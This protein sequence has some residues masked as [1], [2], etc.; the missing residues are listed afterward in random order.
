VST[1]VATQTELASLARGGDVGSLGALLETYRP[2]LYAT[3]V[4]LLASRA[5]ALDAVQETCVVA[6][7]RLGDLRDDG[8]ARAWLHAV[9]RNVCL[10]RMRERRELP[11]EIVE[12]P[13]ST[14]DPAEILERHIARDWV[15]HALDALPADELLTIVLRHFTRCE[16]YDAIARLTA[17]PV[18]TV[19]SRLSRARS[20]LAATMLDAAFGPTEDHRNVDAARREHWELFY[21]ELHEHPAPRTYKELFTHNVD[22]RDRRGHW[23]G[24][25]DWSAHEREAIA[26]GVRA[27]IV[28]VL[29]SS[30]L[31]VIEIDFTNPAGLTHCPPQAT[32]VHNLDQGRSHLLRIHYPVDRRRQP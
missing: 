5:D 14:P 32:F 27:K 26:L 11:F 17:V 18:G 28:D 13:G 2:S 1:D 16:S 31:T 24:L 23:V 12:P 30:D 10:M 25:A 20:R 3:A 19:R 15:W 29:G 21:R 7:L 9:L 4:G 6:L 22:V 8:A